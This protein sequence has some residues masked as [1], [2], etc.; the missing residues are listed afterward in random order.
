MKFGFV[1]TAAA[2][3]AIR[4]ADCHYNACSIAAMANSNKETELMLFPELCLTS[5]SC[6]DLFTQSHFIASCNSA[7]TEIAEATKQ[8]NTIIVFGAPIAHRNALY[9]C[10]VVMHKGDI[11]GI[12][13]KKELNRKSNE[14]RWFTSGNTLP[15]NSYTTIEG[16]RVPI[17]PNGLFTTDS[18]TFGIEI[19]SEAL[20]PVSPAATLSIAGA[21]IILNPT[22]EYPTA[23]EHKAIVARI[24][25]QSARCK[26][27][28][29][30]AGSGWGEST[31]YAV[32]AGFCAIAENGE[33]IATSKRY[34]TEESCIV[35]EVDVERTATARKN[36]SS[37]TQQSDITEITVPQEQSGSK[38]ILR[39]FKQQPFIPQH[40]S[41]EEYCSEIFDIQ[42][43]ALARR[44]QYVGAKSCVIG[45]SGGLD[46][47]LAL[48]VVAA[49]CD[50]IGKPHSDITTVTMPGFGTSGRTYNNAM[51]LMRE[52]GTTIKEISI[53]DA[54]IQHFK[55]IE[56]NIEVHDITYENAQARE[57][58][59]ILMDIANK[60]GG[61]VIGTGDLSELALGWATYNGDQMS[62]YGVNASVP[63]TMMQHIVRWA[64]KNT[65]NENVRATLLDIVDTP[66][67]PELT[68]ADNKGNIK[69][70]TEDLVGPYELH[71]FFLYHFLHHGFSPRK[72]HFMASN[73]FEGKYDSATIKEWL[74]T[75][76]RR[77]FAQQFK[78]TA[79]PDGPQATSCSLSLQNG[80]IMTADT[81]ATTWSSD[82]E[83]IE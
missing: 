9:N 72:I 1:K 21:H 42:K 52:L 36:N 23:G 43:T 15:A 25:Q 60:Q 22:A 57:R 51:A 29:I 49:A 37:F 26:C 44:I 71:D 83:D 33:T 47:T 19:G 75:F 30:T 66:I 81:C 80:W 70:K 24:E 58:T 54:C 12:V 55:D 62:M 48:L 34:N 50:L 56:H 73:A 53:K 38:N 77:F 17:I 59:Q 14:Q 65:T 8:S 2:T 64:A 74:T 82:C 13:P 78:R 68:P 76:T 46:S 11:V 28:Y 41:I 61:I 6:G 4:V 27:C 7:I 10:A 31:S 5:S 39:K 35:T 16:Q 67:S 40:Y 20:S 32:H 69:Q 3:P 18:Y 79:M 45:I 63:K